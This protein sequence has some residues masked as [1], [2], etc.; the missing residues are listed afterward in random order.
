MAIFDLKISG[1]INNGELEK[2]PKVTINGEDIRTCSLDKETTFVFSALIGSAMHLDED[3]QNIILF[4]VVETLSKYGY[5]EIAKSVIDAFNEIRETDA[6]EF[7]KLME[8][9][10][11]DKLSQ[12]AKENQTLNH[13]PFYHA[14]H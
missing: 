13:Q 14:Q 2:A 10:V 12:L 9:F 1:A 3:M 6:L 7:K 4:S 8:S 5:E 11:N